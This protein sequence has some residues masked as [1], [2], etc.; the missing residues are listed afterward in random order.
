MACSGSSPNYCLTNDGPFSNLQPYIYWTKNENA[1]ETFRAWSVHFGAGSQD[2]YL[3]S[4]TVYAW[5]V[6]NGDIALAAVPVPAA[7]WLF[8][9]TLG[10]LGWVR[11]RTGVT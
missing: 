4:S 5:A 9:S 1:G 2:S 6:R 11:R 3:K 7:A 8:G 10:V